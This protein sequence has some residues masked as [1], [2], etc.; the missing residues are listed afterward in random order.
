[1]HCDNCDQFKASIQHDGLL[2][3]ICPD[4]G[5]DLKKEY[6][7]KGLCLN[8]AIA[9]EEHDSHSKMCRELDCI[10]SELKHVKEEFVRVSSENEYMRKVMRDLKSN[11]ISQFPNLP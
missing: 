10:S 4:C 6:E 5:I 11:L 7:S 1:M 2:A 9:I 3:Y 8:C